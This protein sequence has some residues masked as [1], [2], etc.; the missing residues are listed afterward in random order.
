M[1][2]LSQEPPPKFLR[3]SYFRRRGDNHESQ[4]CRFNDRL[5]ECIRKTPCQVCQAWIPEN[6]NAH[7]KALKQKL[8]RKAASAV[9]KMQESMMDDSVELHAL[10]DSLCGPTAK[11]PKS[12]GSTPQKSHPS[13]SS[14]TS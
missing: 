2:T 8:K 14:A 12:D 1:T 6:W 11:I 4:Q 9:K 13:K 10:E 3:C 7:E 5:H